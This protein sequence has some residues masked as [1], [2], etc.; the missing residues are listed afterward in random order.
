MVAV[1][2][3]PDG[4]QREALVRVVLA[5][6]LLKLEQMVMVEERVQYLQQLLQLAVGVVM[7]LLVEMEQLTE[8]RLEPEEVPSD[9]Q[10]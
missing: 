4:Q 7:L 3:Q 9:L 10:T 5:H 6:Q 2:V 8:G 1:M